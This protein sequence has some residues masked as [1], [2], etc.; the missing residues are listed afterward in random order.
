MRSQLLYVA[1]E[2]RGGVVDEAAARGGLSCSPLVEQDDAEDGGVEEAG[3]VGETAGS[4]TPVKDW[5]GNG[6]R[7]EGEG[8]G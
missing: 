1:C 5:E 7:E 8:G 3:V 4:W 6:N 2:V